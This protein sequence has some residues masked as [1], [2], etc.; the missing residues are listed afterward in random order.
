MEL[1]WF[2]QMIF[3]NAAKQIW[4]LI[5]VYGCMAEKITNWK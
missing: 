5:V 1:Q 4:L 2:S 3:K